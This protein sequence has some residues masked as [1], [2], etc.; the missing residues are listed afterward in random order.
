MGNTRAG[1]WLPS[2]LTG[3]DAT[4]GIQIPILQ[5]HAP[6]AIIRNGALASTTA[7]ATTTTCIRSV[8]LFTAR[9]LAIQ[10]FPK[11]VSVNRPHAESGREQ[12]PPSSI[13][14]KSVQLVRQ[15]S[16]ISNFSRIWL[17][18][19]VGAWEPWRTYVMA[20]RL[21]YT[22]RYG[23]CCRDPAASLPDSA[24]APLLLT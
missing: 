4:R 11:A 10:R 12:P 8:H 15:A 19:P 9:H 21:T 23:P 17:P 14:C 18:R 5:Q 2:S 13:V 3:A 16:Q 24:P 7:R 1:A 22:R 6:T 20:G